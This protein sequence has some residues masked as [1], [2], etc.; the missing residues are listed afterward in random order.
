MALAYQYADS[1]GRQIDLINEL[2]NQ[3][4][5]GEKWLD[6]NNVLSSPWSRNLEIGVILRL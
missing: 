1:K 2:K 6:W 5:N 3:P 4:L